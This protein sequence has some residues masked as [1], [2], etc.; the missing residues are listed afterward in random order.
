[1]A[2]CFGRDC[3]GESF[4]RGDFGAF[5]VL[6]MALHEPLLLQQLKP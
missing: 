6:A 3:P 5:S 2:L 1:M 4:L